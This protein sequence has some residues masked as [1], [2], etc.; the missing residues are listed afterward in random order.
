[1]FEFNKNNVYY[2]DDFWK[3]KQDLLEKIEEFINRECTQEQLI[4]FINDTF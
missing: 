2:Y 3:N 1:M 4:Y